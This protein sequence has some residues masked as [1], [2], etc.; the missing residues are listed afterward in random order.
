MQ[1]EFPQLNA[2][3]DRVGDMPIDFSRLFAMLYN[4]LDVQIGIADNKAQ[5]VVAANSI[6]LASLALTGTGTLASPSL[7][8]DAPLD[9][10]LAIVLL[11]AT[12]A[13]LAASI[14]QALRS[15]RPNLRGPKAGSNLFFFGDIASQN[16]DDFVARFSAMSADDLKQAIM[17]QVHAKSLIVTAKYVH[18]RSSMHFLFAALALWLA[19]RL[20]L[21]L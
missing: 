15:S 14:F 4:G 12:A 1:N 8:S 10:R 2:I 21:A 9:A 17:R 3:D 7:A 11:V 19:M 5:I 20:L 13:C 6:L 18:L 16:E